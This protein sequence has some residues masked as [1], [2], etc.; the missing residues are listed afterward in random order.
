MG[1]GTLADYIRT[2]ADLTSDQAE[3]LRRLCQSWQVL[4]DLSFSDLLLY[5][6]ASGDEVFE[7]VAQLRPFTSQTLYPHDMVGTRVTQPEQPIVERAYREGEIWAQDDPV[8]VD[9]IPI[10]MDAVPVRFR[11]EVIGVVTKEGSPATSRRP[12]R[13]EQVYLE[14][15]D[16]VSRMIA[17][18]VFPY[19]QHPAGEWPRVSDGLF[20]LDA[21][22]RIEWAS[23][24]ALSSLRR[25]GIAHNVLGRF[26]DELGLGETPVREAMM[27][28][29]L[30]DGELVRGDAHIRLRV[31]PLFSDGKTTRGLV[32]TRD[33]TELREKERVISVKDATIREIH[34]RVKNNLQTIA[35][36]LR[37]QSR[38]LHSEEAKAALQES[39]LRIGS[40]AL[41]H[42]I[43]SEEPEDVGEFG[44]VARRISAMVGEALVL[45]DQTVEVK[46][47]GKSGPLGAELATPLAVTLAELLQ[48]AVEHAF[49][50][51]RSGTVKVELSR[52]GDEVVV[53]VWDDGIGMQQPLEGSR[54]GLQIVRSLIV[55]LGGSFDV[56]SEA[57]TRVELRVPTK[58]K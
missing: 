28:Q 54:L 53:V 35:S 10:R 33:V 50:D 49:P 47:T 45:P 6:R 55:E 51:G 32:L 11:G 58:R 44:E 4:A 9:G 43:L 37:L 1:M 3:H 21:E 56:T 18:G 29:E 17:D 42:E 14:A 15:G 36:L 5:V 46:V 23:P 26:L 7:V 2:R 22:G 57:G 16:R 40:I 8:L 38:R 52:E 31:I 19:P 41:V 30:Q 34:H 20:V 27:E 25:L 13:L 39:V 48:N 24:N 12:G